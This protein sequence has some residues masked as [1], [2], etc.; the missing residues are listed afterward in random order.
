MYDLE[1]IRKGIHGDLAG[2]LEFNRTGAFQSDAALSLAA[3]FPPLDRM[4]VTTGLTEPRDFASHGYDLLKALSDASPK[5][6]ATFEDILDFGVGAGRL[7]RMFKG[8]R[9]RYTGVDVDRQ[10]IL[11]VAETL[12]WV[13]AIHTRPRRPLPFPEGRFDAVIS[14]SVFSHMN[15]KDQFFYLGE[16]AR[17]V[18]P[19]AIVMLSIHGERA[20]ARAET[21]EKIFKMLQ[22]PPEALVKTR[23]KLSEGGF[24][25][26]RHWWGHLT[27]LFY[28]YGQTF[29]SRAYIEREWKK[30]FDVLDI[31][32]GAIHDF[33][34]IVVLKAR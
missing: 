2:W 9:G 6:L 14:I 29:I 4:H 13:S 23:R 16:L 32:S 34:D 26:I 30:Y 8:Y 18:R 17:I 11:W 3:P 10:N 19:G 20:L 25:F 7:A 24:R 1:D 33:Q 28:A 21:E 5:P 15:E 22:V 31:R 27:T 12:P